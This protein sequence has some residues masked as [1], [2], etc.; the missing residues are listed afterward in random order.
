MLDSVHYDNLSSLCLSVRDGCRIGGDKLPQTV[1]LLITPRIHPGKQP[2]VT[3]CV[4]SKA[5]IPQ[6]TLAGYLP[7]LH[8]K[9]ILT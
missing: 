9:M 7:T 4:N 8:H 2:P 6:N 3:P 5:G 1:C